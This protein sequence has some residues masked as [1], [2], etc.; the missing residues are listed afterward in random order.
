[1]AADP[2]SSI[3]SSSSVSV[4][5]PLT[6]A[7]VFQRRTAHAAHSETYHL[8]GCCCCLFVFT[9][10][11][12]LCVSHCPLPLLSI[13]VTL[14]S[15]LCVSIV[16]CHCAFVKDERFEV[17]DFLVCSSWFCSFV[18]VGIGVCLLVRCVIICAHRILFAAVAQ[19]RSMCNGFYDTC[20]C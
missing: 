18:V 15:Y 11:Y 3:S 17:D 1:M 12:Y 20:C 19:S 8:S 7:V 6:R 5:W 9:L 2:S 10:C 13:A 4:A 16:H 14:C